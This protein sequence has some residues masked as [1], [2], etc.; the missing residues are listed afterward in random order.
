MPQVGCSLRME[1][2]ANRRRRGRGAWGSEQ[3]AC[4][5]GGG[6]LDHGGEVCEGVEVEDDGATAGGDKYEAF[7]C[8]VDGVDLRA[9][10]EE[11]LTMQRK[12]WPTWADATGPSISDY[13]LPHKAT[14]KALWLK[15][16]D[17]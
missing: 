9:G 17:I 12:I 5:G 7:G 16:L 6:G 4:C 8:T 2:E 1:K 14:Q 10:L 11:V 13:A 15:R 3:S